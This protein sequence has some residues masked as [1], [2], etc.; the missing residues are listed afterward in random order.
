M[1]WGD[2][3]SELLPPDRFVPAAGQG[4]LCI[5]AR[6][7]DDF[8][9]ELLKK[10][11][12]EPTALA[13]R[14]ERALLGRLEGGCQV[15]MGAYATLAPFASA[16]EPQALAMTAVVGTPDGKE[17]LRA[18]QTGSGADPEQLGLAV[19]EELLARGADRILAAG[20]T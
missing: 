11:Q 12:H 13:V 19:A 6:A 3:I 8:V 7:G 17:L 15:P 14:A 1:G 5:E 4:A 9:L 16:G 2:R 20:R 10:L 18:V